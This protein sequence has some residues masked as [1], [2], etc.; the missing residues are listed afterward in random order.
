LIGTRTVGGVQEFININVSDT[1]NVVN[2]E[3]FTSGMLVVDDMVVTTDGYLLAVGKLSNATDYRLRQWQYPS[4][5]LVIDS[6]LNPGF[7]PSGVFV[8]AGL[9]YVTGVNGQVYKINDTTP[10]NGVLVNNS[11]EA[12]EGVSQIS[13]CITNGLTPASLPQ[14]LQLGSIPG[15]Q[16]EFFIE[17]AGSSVSNYST[18]NLSAVWGDG[19]TN[20]TYSAAISGRIGGANFSTNPYTSNHLYGAASSVIANLT[21]TMLPPTGTQ[22]PP[23]PIDALYFRR[24]SSINAP[25]QPFS[26]MMGTTGSGLRTLAFANSNLTNNISSI[27]CPPRLLNLFFLTCNLG[28]NFTPSFSNNYSSVLNRVTV[29]SCTVTNLNIDASTASLS[30]YNV[31]LPNLYII[32]NIGLQNSTIKFPNSISFLWIEGNT[33]LTSLTLLSSTQ[34]G[35]N[36]FSDCTSITRLHILSNR[37]TT[38]S[39]NL[40]GNI[41]IIRIEVNRIN[42]TSG[43]ISTFTSNF[44]G[45]NSLT[46][47]YYTSNRT[48]TLNATNLNTC[49]TLRNLRLN[50]NL[51]TSVPPLPAEIIQFWV[52]NNKLTIRPTFPSNCLVQEICF[53]GNGGSFTNSTTANSV[54]T[55]TG[56]LNCNTLDGQFNVGVSDTYLSDLTQLLR[57]KARNC[58][59]AGW[60]CTFPNS[61]ETIDLTS[62]P[63]GAVNTPFF[64]NIPT[65]NFNNFTRVINLWVNNANVSQLFELNSSTRLSVLSLNTNAFTNQNNFFSTTGSNTQYFPTT[66]TR[67]EIQVNNIQIWNRALFPPTGTL[68]ILYV[69]MR[70]L[71]LQAISINYLL[72]Y[73]ANLKT[74]GRIPNMANL[75]LEGTSGSFPNLA[76]DTTSGGINGCAALNVLRNATAPTV[77][78]S[79][80]SGGPCV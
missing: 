57:F 24:I 74:A 61:I 76:P 50:D 42:N 52:N 11:P 75:L 62:G 66:L 3:L 72:N 54:I 63:G 31:S 64:N 41:T 12:Y 48:T 13:S 2:T 71:A 44:N 38:W 49:S 53:G 51:L 20:N 15:Q 69:D 26:S 7:D 46:D 70:N 35:N 39:Y 79:I 25:Q 56:L 32:N 4:G 28:S 36:A 6:A 18:L 23:L 60:N 14:I 58:R 45:N 73:F 43:G 21:F 65:L 1:A 16:M 27:S 34:T 5:T 37:I 40:N 10:W 17:T 68:S 29:E 67:L 55:D 47:F 9:V 19:T 59:L 8:S 22:P 33:S 30:A 80:T 78:V 77:A